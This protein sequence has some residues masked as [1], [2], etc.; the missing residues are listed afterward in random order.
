[1]QLQR[2]CCSTL[3]WLILFSLDLKRISNDLHHLSSALHRVAA[4][5]LDRL[6][7]RMAVGWHRAR[8]GTFGWGHSRDCSKQQ[9]LAILGHRVRFVWT[10]VRGRAFRNSISLVPAQK[11]SASGRIGL[12]KR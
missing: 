7:R 3:R 9:S 8:F 2:S 4:L 10:S 5:H 11:T 12:T 1:M 6:A